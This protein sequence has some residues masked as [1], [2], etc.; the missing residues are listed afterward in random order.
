MSTTT[1]D[2][3]LADLARPGPR[4][5]RTHTLDDRSTLAAVMR[6]DL[7]LDRLVVVAVRGRARSRPPRRRRRSS[8]RSSARSGDSGPDRPHDTAAV[9]S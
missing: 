5:F 7:G 8:A 9:V 3:V 1:Q 2:R 4:T 6:R